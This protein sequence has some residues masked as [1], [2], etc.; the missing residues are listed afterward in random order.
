[1]I[2]KHLLIISAYLDPE[3]GAKDIL[4]S[5]KKEKDS[6]PILPEKSAVETL[7]KNKKSE[8]QEDKFLDEIINKFFT[9]IYYTY[10]LRSTK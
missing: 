2:W 7:R 6:K 5:S 1:M 3:G 8:S 10:L 9:R 4:K